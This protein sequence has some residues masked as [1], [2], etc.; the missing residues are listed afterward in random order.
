M[1]L[2]VD[3]VGLNILVKDSASFAEN[4]LGFDLSYPQDFSAIPSAIITVISAS[5]N[6]ETDRRSGVYYFYVTTHGGSSFGASLLPYLEETFKLYFHNGGSPP[7]LSPIASDNHQEIAFDLSGPTD[8]ESL[9]SLIADSFNSLTSSVTGRKL[10]HVVDLNTEVWSGTERHSAHLS[11]PASSAASGAFSALLMSRADGRVIFPETAVNSGNALYAT[12]IGSYDRHHSSEEAARARGWRNTYLNPNLGLLNSS[13]PQKSSSIPPFET[14]TYTAVPIVEPG[15]NYFNALMTHRNGPYGHSTWR[16]IR[17]ADNPITRRQNKQSDMTFVL[18]QGPIRNIKTTGEKFTRD[19]YSKIYRFKEPVATQTSKP[20]VWLAGRHFNATYIDGEYT[21]EGLERFSILSSYGNNLL[22]FSND[23]VNKLLQYELDDDES[24]YEFI[25]RFYIH[26]GLE[27]EES[28]FT[29]WEFL[30]YSETVWPQ[31]VNMFRKQTRMRQN[32]SVGFHEKRSLRNISSSTDYFSVGANSAYLSPET[33]YLPDSFRSMW[34]LDARD[35]MLTTFTG[36]SFS[37]GYEENLLQRY[38]GNTGGKEGVLM[39]CYGQ[40]RDDNGIPDLLALGEESRIQGVDRDMTCHAYY[41]RRHTMLHTQSVSNPSG[42]YIPETGSGATALPTASFGTGVPLWEA[43]EQAG[44]WPY[45]NSYAEWSEDIRRVGKAYSIIPEFAMSKRVPLLIKSS[46]LFYPARHTTTQNAKYLITDNYDYRP[47]PTADHQDYMFSLTGSVDYA[48]IDSQEGFFETYS[49]SDFMK[50]FEVINDDH[51]E[52]TKSQVLT[53][54]CKAIKKFLPYRGF[55]PVERTLKMAGQFYDSYARNIRGRVDGYSELSPQNELAGPVQILKQPILS[56]LFAPGVL[57]NAIKSGVAVDYPIITSSLTVCEPGFA[58]YRGTGNNY[59]FDQGLDGSGNAAKTNTEYM[60]A[61]G[62]DKRI[63]FEAL[64]NPENYLANINVTCQEPHLSGNLSAS[65]IWDGSGDDLY[66]MMAHNF[67]AE[68]PNF[69]LKDQNFTSITSLPQGDP[70]FGN[71][72]K[73]KVYGMR[74]KMYRS[75]NARRPTVTASVGLH[76]ASWIPYEPPQDI[77]DG[78]CYE[79][80][81]MYSR[82]SAFGPPS[83][84]VTSIHDQDFSGNGAAHDY[85]LMPATWERNDERT[86]RTLWA[87]ND[88]PQNSGNNTGSNG[89]CWEFSKDSRM[90][91][92]FPF[93]PPYYH[94]QAWLDIYYTGSVDGKV[95]L[96]E[97]L[98]YATSSVTRFDPHVYGVDWYHGNGGVCNW[99]PGQHDSDPIISPFNTDDTVPNKQNHPQAVPNVNLN[100]CQITASINAFG[101]GA[102]K[103]IN[104]LGDDTANEVA[105]VVNTNSEDE[106]RWVIQTKFETPMLNFNHVSTTS[107]TLTLPSFASGSGGIIGDTIAR[108]MWHQLGRL[109]EANEGVFLQI[110]PIPK[111]WLTG[112]ANIDPEQ[113]SNL[114]DVCGFSAEPIKLGKIA[115]SKVIYEAVVAVPYI[116]DKGAKKFF[117]LD[118]REV[119]KWKLQKRKDRDENNELGLSIKHQLDKMKKYVFPPSMDFLTNHAVD[120]FAMYIFEFSHRL[121]QEDLSYIWQN[122]PPKIMNTHETA[123]S[124]ITHPLLAKELLGGGKPGDNTPHE[125]PNKLRW[126]VFKVKQRA[127]SNYYKK[128]VSKDSSRIAGEVEASLGNI[129]MDQFGSTAKIQYNW[130]YDYFSLVELAQID[131]EVEWVDADFSAF[132]ENFPSPTGRSASPGSIIKANLEPFEI[133]EAEGPPPVPETPEEPLPGIYGV[134]CRPYKNYSGTGM[135]QRF[136]HVAGVTEKWNIAAN[137]IL[138]GL[139]M[140]GVWNGTSYDVNSSKQEEPGYSVL[141]E[142]AVQAETLLDSLPLCPDAEDDAPGYTQ[143]TGGFGGPVASGDPD[144]IEIPDITTKV[145]DLD[146][147]TGAGGGGD[148]DQ[149]GCVLAGTLIETV[150]GL[151]PAEEVKKGDKIYSYD[152]DSKEYG[153]YEVLSVRTPV[154]RTQ[155]VHIKTGLGKSL[156]C[157]VDHPLYTFARR[158]NELPVAEAEIGTTVYVMSEG[159]ITKD[160][161]TEINYIHENTMVYNFEVDVVHSY[162]SDGILSHNKAGGQPGGG[163][164]A[165]AGIT[166]PA[167]I[168]PK[169]LGEG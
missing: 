112:S 84:G 46:S 87:Q 98:Q 2:F 3:H 19:R 141:R 36:S 74:I 116:V 131:A 13:W 40:L 166:G 145:A 130:P 92:N 16:Q 45:P 79:N 47:P 4:T 156:R 55:Y 97:I 76:S 136:Y 149:G 160:N 100:A 49:N 69:F 159:N 52:F 33:T 139:W 10:L 67:L 102:L 14:F 8:N 35:D 154:Q 50:S 78:T 30:R 106:A 86:V 12:T 60:I 39:G 96:S 29:Y 63:P 164:S 165:D 111:S 20:L 66:K 1:S 83:A 21:G 152:F 41:A 113:V 51:N 169:K 18:D 25:K 110:G 101:R 89:S 56:P 77:V 155:W 7:T 54:K 11:P 57:F 140:E 147:G 94:G 150:R 58:A 127:A 38:T 168:I 133:W 161:I 88:G 146:Y 70:N 68:V 137:T 9:Y 143:G 109:P 142:M 138:S 44:V 163:G 129:T 43:A 126:M 85:Q 114:A 80:F 117:E 115:D 157:S 104:L 62:F 99:R 121:D 32:Y 42:M 125:L 75:M 107:N 5:G 122:L 118:K 27:K 15:S 108:G 128:I 134:E 151:V 135:G 105:V 64:V 53:L 65:A 162:I 17:T 119:S 148:A 71:V 167:P 90:G 95:S 22:G 6:P 37:A 73:D 158:N 153:Y 34:P 120:P 61:R 93:T 28:P 81:T 48:T 24:E 23:R 123:T 82:P 72:I 132:K 59:R 103:S 144:D 91:Y 26:G 124:V 31:S